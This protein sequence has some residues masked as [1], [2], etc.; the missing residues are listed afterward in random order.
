MLTEIC[1]IV[2]KDSVNFLQL[3]PYHLVSEKGVL[4]YTLLFKPLKCIL[5][6]EKRVKEFV[7]KHGYDI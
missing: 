6:A 2:F 4:H 7:F 5:I 3:I 1:I